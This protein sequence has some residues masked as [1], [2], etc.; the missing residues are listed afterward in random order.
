MQIE[1]NKNDRNVVKKRKEKKNTAER[2][3][4]RIYLAGEQ[5]LQMA[6][7]IILVQP[8]CLRISVSYLGVSGLPPQAA[9]SGIGL[10][11]IN[12]NLTK[13]LAVSANRKRDLDITLRS[14]DPVFQQIAIS[15]AD[16]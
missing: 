3:K 11:T 15:S 6:Y 2:N 14:F 8:Q 10:A 7:R 1:V 16:N 4:P 9:C 5:D 12:I 13:L